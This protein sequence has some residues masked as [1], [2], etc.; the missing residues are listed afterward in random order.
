MRIFY[1]FGI[2]A[3]ISA[4]ALL[5]FSSPAAA[6]DGTVTVQFT[7]GNGNATGAATSYLASLKSLWILTP[8]PLTGVGSGE[9]QEM[10]TM[11]PRG[12]G[13]D[14]DKDKDKDPHPDPRPMPEG[15]SPIV[16][17]LLA[18]LACGGAIFFRKRKQIGAP[19]FLPATYR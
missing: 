2:L 13:P 16:Y 11:L 7:G 4:L 3:A 14:K 5:G 12:E 18:I 19:N 8:D 17:L 9:P 6:A 1:R 15:G 10:L